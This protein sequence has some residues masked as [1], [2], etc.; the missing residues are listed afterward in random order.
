MFVQRDMIIRLGMFP[1]K[2]KVSSATVGWNN[3]L[4]LISNP[5]GRVIA[6]LSPAASSYLNRVIC[7][8]ILSELHFT[9]LSS[10]A[11]F[12][13]SAQ[14]LLD[15]RLFSSFPFLFLRG[16][17][18]LDYHSS[19]EYIFSAVWSPV[20]LR[21]GSYCVTLQTVNREKSVYIK[22]RYVFVT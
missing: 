5:Y 6:E 20:H 18:S 11:L 12:T 2:L 21:I 16:F 13:S 17:S 22:S 19:S 8:Y 7:F 1:Q 3:Y 4:V 10:S 14:G 15:L 9:H